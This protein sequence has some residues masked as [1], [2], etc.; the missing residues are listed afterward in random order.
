MGAIA[1]KVVVIV[2]SDDSF[3]R[4][5][6]GIVFDQGGSSNSRFPGSASDPWL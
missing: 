3:H 1:M 2:T 6:G 4:L 5:H